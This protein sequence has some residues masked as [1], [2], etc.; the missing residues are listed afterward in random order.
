MPEYRR[1]AVPGGTYFFTVKTFERKQI[2]TQEPYRVAL[3]QAIAEVRASLP[4]ESIAWILLP[5]HLHT[6]WKL[7]EGDANFSLRWSLIKQRVTRQCA[8][9]TGSAS[10]TRSQ[11]KR[12][13]GTIW[14]RRFW[15]HVI[16]NDADLEQHVNYIH[17]NPVKHGYVSR[18]RDWPYSTFHRFVRRGVGKR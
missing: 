1:A 9:D 14:Q 18:A 2:L 3:R 13:E 8:G 17:Y 4:F 10:T 6:V 5:D 12:R 7:P 16:R 15:E 11:Q